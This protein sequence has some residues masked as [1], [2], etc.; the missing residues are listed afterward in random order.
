MLL[1]DRQ[2]EGTV[3]DFA[4]SSAMEPRFSHESDWFTM[5]G[6]SV[7]VTTCAGTNAGC[8]CING[9]S[10]SMTFMASI[11]HWCFVD[12]FHGSGSDHRL[13]HPMGLR[14][15]CGTGVWL[16]SDRSDWRV[17]L[18]RHLAESKDLARSQAREGQ[19][20][21]NEY[22]VGTL[23]RPGTTA[24]SDP[25][26]EALEA[27][28]GGAAKGVV[29]SAVVGTPDD[30]VAFIQNM[31]ELTGGFGTAIGFVHDWANLLRSSI[32]GILS[33]VMSFQRSTVTRRN[34]GNLRSL[35]LI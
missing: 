11:A 17:L 31:Y 21:H 27:V 4:T 22:I 20:W 19:R 2:D 32:V 28:C 26:S 35:S 10:C 12:W 30:L 18:V 13:W 5:K 34:L 1:R 8:D 14:R 9:P 23:Q 3:G 15:R 6:R 7:A 25:E 29:Q 33:L 16:V 24:Y